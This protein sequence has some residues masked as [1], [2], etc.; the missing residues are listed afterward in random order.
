MLLKANRNPRSLCRYE[1]HVNLI[2]FPISSLDIVCTVTSK[3]CCLVTK[4]PSCANEVKCSTC[5][6]KV[7]IFN[8]MGSEG[9][10]I[11]KLLCV[12]C[13]FQ[14]VMASNRRAL[15]KLQS[16]SFRIFSLLSATSHYFDHQRLFWVT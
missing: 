15:L 3:C 16:G 5:I 6:G 11:E 1:V 12:T 2:K 10:G 13:D 4:S 9:E 7:A 8:M 14:A